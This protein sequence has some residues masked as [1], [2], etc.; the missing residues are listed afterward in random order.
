MVA[1]VLTPEQIKSAPPEVRAWIERQI[2][3][4]FGRAAAMHAAGGTAPEQPMPQ[5]QHAPAFAAPAPCDAAAAR[6]ILEQMRGDPVA[7][8]VFLELGRP[9]A[10]AAVQSSP[11][12]MHAIPLAGVMAHTG[13]AEASRLT[14]YLAAIN[15][16]YRIATGRPGGIVALDPRG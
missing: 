7:G 11:L 2:D 8:R 10:T 16:L 6:A 14:A 5:Q 4:D 3:A 1:I 12:A 9:D 15:E 13:I